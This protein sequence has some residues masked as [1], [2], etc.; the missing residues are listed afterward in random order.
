M[1]VMIERET[2]IA[3]GV[4]D[5]FEELCQ[6]LEGLVLPDGY[7]AEIIRGNIVVSPWSKAYYLTV[8]D[9]V[10]DQ[11]RPH[12]PPEHLIS[13]GPALYV[14][15]E[16]ERAYGPDIHAAHRSTRESESIRLD[17]EGLSFV[18]ELTSPTTR[19][20][21]FHDKAEQ[22]G[23]AGVPVYLLL[24]MQEERATVLWAP[25]EGREGYSSQMTVPFGEKLRMPAPFGCEL[26]TSG[27]RR[28]EA[29]S[30]AER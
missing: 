21:D 4:P 2:A 27:F 24:D 9:L 30:N 6:V 3:D 20:D 11:L 18:A 14:F 13:Y 12:L 17:G 26:D 5:G 15:P 1:T 23:A 25:G 28:P 22:Y 19:D 29:G 16:V 10:C 7:K 8:M